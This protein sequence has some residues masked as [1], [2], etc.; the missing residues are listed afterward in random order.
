MPL[1]PKQFAVNEVWFAIRV[2]R[3]PVLIAGMPNHIYVVQD[4]GSMFV[5]GNAFAPSEDE[6]PS[7]GDAAIILTQAWQEKREWPKKLL[8]PGTSSK[9]N[10]FAAAAEMKKVEVAFVPELELSFYIDDLQSSY[11]EF[12]ARGAAKHT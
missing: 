6:S 8:I 10:G 11:E 12:I 3:N 4:A 9:N 7:A 1:H 2:T 5:F